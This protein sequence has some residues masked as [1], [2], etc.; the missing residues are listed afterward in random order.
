MGDSNREN[1]ERF[2][3]GVVMPFVKLA[4]FLVDL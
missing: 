4:G 2:G 1:Y 3:K